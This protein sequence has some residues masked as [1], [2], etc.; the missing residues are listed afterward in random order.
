MVEYRQTMRAIVELQ[1]R[2][3]L[4]QGDSLLNVR[5]LLLLSAVALVVQVSITD[6]GPGE[7]GAAA[8]W[9]AIGC[10]MLWLV[11]R[12]HSRV[13]RAMVVV[14]SM[15]GAVIYAFGFFGD[16]NA[17]ALVLAYV[18]QAVPLLLNPVRHHVSP[19]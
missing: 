17:A 3:A 13:A 12:K 1:S 10:L 18:G 2:T 11:Y 14:S 8:L 7:S 16:V 9:L 19:A 4:L 6:Y 5:N 15:V